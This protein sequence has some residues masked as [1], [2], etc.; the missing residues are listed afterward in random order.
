MEKNDYKINR[1]KK[2][3]IKKRNCKL[4]Y[5]KIIP[6]ILIF[7]ATLV[8]G[9][10]KTSLDKISGWE[11][12]QSHI[13]NLKEKPD[14]IIMASGKTY[15]WSIKKCN[16]DPAKK[17]CLRGKF[18]K[19][20]RTG[21][22]RLF[23]GFYPLY[24]NGSIIKNYNT[25]VIP[26]TDTELVAEASKGTTELKIKNGS[27]WEV[28]SNIKIAFNTKPDGQDLPNFNI[29]RSKIIS[30]TKTDG[31]WLVKL[32]KPLKARLPAGT[33]LRQHRRE[34]DMY[35]ANAKPLTEE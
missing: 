23:F 26:E 17:Y 16:I 32:E 8:Y 11:G 12:G 31:S 24:K 1:F 4:L 9:E 35:Y 2:N 34:G 13:E 7:A 20:S 21:T 10:D 22:A 5:P 14:G 29:I 25:V 33:H 18:R 15:L 3:K 19:A 30:V 28:L 27:K 6:V